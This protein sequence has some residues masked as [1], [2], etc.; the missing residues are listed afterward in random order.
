MPFLLRCLELN[1]PRV[2][3]GNYLARV[4]DIESAFEFWVPSYQ[5]A[6]DMK[7]AGGQVFLYSFDYVKKGEEAISP[8]HAEDMSYNLR[9]PFTP[10]DERDE[11]IREIYPDYYANFAKV[12]STHLSCI[13]ARRQSRRALVFVQ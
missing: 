10:Q 9:D 11:Q 2:K 4:T 3:A 1:L 5:D 8:Y 13:I 6:S 12:H 7:A